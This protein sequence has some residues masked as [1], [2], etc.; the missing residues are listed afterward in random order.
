MR[1]SV[2]VTL[3]VETLTQW[4]KKAERAKKSISKN[5]EGSKKL[6]QKC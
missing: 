3:I 6:C 1:K 2:G 4:R 5:G